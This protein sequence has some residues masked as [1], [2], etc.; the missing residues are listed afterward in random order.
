MTQIMPTDH[1]SRQWL[2]GQGEI[3]MVMFIMPHPNLLLIES[4][5][6][7][8]VITR[9]CGQYG[10]LQAGIKDHFFDVKARCHRVFM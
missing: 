7:F 4:D 2:A 6:R 1:E 9:L 5:M 8:E 3:H 10:R